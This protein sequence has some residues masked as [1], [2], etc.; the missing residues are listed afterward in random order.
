MK[1][2]IKLK[3]ENVIILLYF[4]WLII[5]LINKIYILNYKV[6]EISSY[7]I[8]GVIVASLSLYIKELRTYIKNNLK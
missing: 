1:N 7:L 6:I 2:I 8:I 3:I 4:I 5:D